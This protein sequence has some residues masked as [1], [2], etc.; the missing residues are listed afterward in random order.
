AI[1]GY[2]K[3]NKDAQYSM[4]LKKI[5]IIHTTGLLFLGAF[6]GYILVAD[7]LKIEL[8]SSLSYIFNN[9]LFLLIPISYYAV[10]IIFTA[11]NYFS[12]KGSDVS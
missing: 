2:T 6:I 8:P 5:I 4:H 12:I 1:M 9:W 7:F 3:Q 10:I 11:V